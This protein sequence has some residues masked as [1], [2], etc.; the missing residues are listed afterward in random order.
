MTNRLFKVTKKVAKK[1]G[2]G[3]V[4]ALHENSR[5]AKRLRAASSRDETFAKHAALR[6]KQNEPYCAY[7]LFSMYVHGSLIR[8]QWKGSAS[9]KKPPM[10]PPTLILMLMLMLE[11]STLTCS[12]VS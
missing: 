1:K 8:G 10:P 12:I 6:A 3:S 2:R 9:S 11:R 7:E 5:D 4:T